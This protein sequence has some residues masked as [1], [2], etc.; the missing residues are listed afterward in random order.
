MSA[1][2]FNNRLFLIYKKTQLIN[3]IQEAIFRKRV[4]WE[5][6]G[7]TIRQCKRLPF[8]INGDGG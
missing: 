8:Q 2:K 1:F 7:A 4:N 6:N 5:L 3:P